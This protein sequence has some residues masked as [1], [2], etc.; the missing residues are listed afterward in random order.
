MPDPQ[1]I[2]NELEAKIGKVSNHLAINH[3][4]VGQLAKQLGGAPEVADQ[5]IWKRLV[6]RARLF[7]KCLQEIVHED[8][9]VQGETLVPG[10]D[11][12]DVAVDEKEWKEMHPAEHTAHSLDT[13][14][15][16]AIN[17]LRQALDLRRREGS[18]V[19]SELWEELRQEAR[20]WRS[21]LNELFEA[22]RPA[23]DS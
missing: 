8:W 7:I 10:W 20:V 18:C 6:R 1:K 22:N 9:T 14:L 16:A 11:G 2:A 15:A 21:A 19:N 3:H 13:A 17:L 5:G 12:E 4:L 23:A